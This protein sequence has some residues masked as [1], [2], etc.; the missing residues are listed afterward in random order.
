MELVILIGA[1][2][3]TVIYAI[4]LWIAMK[5]M[6]VEGTFLDIFI[7][8][9]IAS[10]FGLL[11]YVGMIASPIA[12]WALICKRLHA[13][14]DEAIYMV[15]AAQLIAVIAGIYIPLFIDRFS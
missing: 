11:P 2:I 3:G 1:A 15:I 13:E 4:C 12:M 5:M 6:K 8:S 10:L 7:I 14:I 9:I